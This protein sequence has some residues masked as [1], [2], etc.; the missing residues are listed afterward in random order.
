MSMRNEIK[1]I[2]DA[3]EA[4]NRPIT[5]EAIVEA[6][7]NAETYPAL[8]EH[9]WQVDAE[10]LAT[11]ARLARAHR[12][13]IS[14]RIVT[15]EG[16]STRLLTHIP[17]IAGYRS[18]GFIASQ[19]DLAAIKL[20]QLTEDISRSRARLR[21]FR[22]LVPSTVADEI[23]AALEAAETRAAAQIETRAEAAA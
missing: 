23:D 1:L 13:L 9:L 12:L 10:T 17:G 20:R 6:A 14:I 21:E 11:E 18:S 8:N 16:N 2:T 15:E 22:S 4:E 5:A 19:V 7:K 3:Y